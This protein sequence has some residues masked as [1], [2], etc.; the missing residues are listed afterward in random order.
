MEVT[1]G[2][3]VYHHQLFLLAESHR[4]VLKSQQDIVDLRGCLLAKAT[5]LQEVACLKNNAKFLYSI[6]GEKKE[7]LDNLLHFKKY[8]FRISTKQKNLLKL[9]LSPT[10]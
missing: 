5:V 6:V 7:V 3:V 1:G 9:I 8:E 4:E 2:W 10:N